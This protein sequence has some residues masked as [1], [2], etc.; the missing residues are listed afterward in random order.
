MAEQRHVS[1]PKP[2][3]S[4][5]AGEWF[6]RFEICCK[7]NAW[8]EKAKVLKLPTLLE[9]E[10]LATWMEL[11]EDEQGDYGAAKQKM[12][13]RMVPVSQGT[14]SPTNFRSGG[15]NSLGNSVPLGP[16]FLGN[17][18]LREYCTSR[19]LGPGGGGGDRVP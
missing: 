13:E 11:S 3:A 5:D 1:I 12:I 16:K 7:A 19:D 15:P 2:F 8:D 9:G 17:W 18:V 14:R 4:G 6:K 10:A